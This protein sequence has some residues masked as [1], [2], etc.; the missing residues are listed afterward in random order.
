MSGRTAKA[1]RKAERAAQTKSRTYEVLVDELDPAELKYLTKVRQEMEGA[2]AQMQALQNQARQLEREIN[3]AAAAHT[4]RVGAW[5][6]YFEHLCEGRE[7]EPATTRISQ[8]GKIYKIVSPDAGDGATPDAPADAERGADLK[9][10][11]ARDL[12]AIAGGKAA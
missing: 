8:E 10:K 9:G 4:Q 6:S 12:D 3:A 5:N 7:L 2:D 1:G 11:T